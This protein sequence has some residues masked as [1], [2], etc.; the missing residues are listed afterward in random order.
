VEGRGVL[1]SRITFSCKAKIRDAP[2]PSGKLAAACFSPVQLSEEKF[3][4]RSKENVMKTDPEK[5]EFSRVPIHLD[6]EIS[7]PQPA[8]HPCQVKDVSLKGLYLLCDNPLPV[9]SVCR[10]A[11]L[12]NGGETPVRIE[13]GGTVARVDTT[14]MGLEITEIV[15]IESFEHLQNLVLYNASDPDQ[16]AHEFQSHLGLK[17]KEE[18][19]S[20]KK[21]VE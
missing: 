12:L 7:S 11:L 17:R 9:G 1:L 19:M 18:R 20:T 4:R 15:G 3:G 13:L 21:P 14:G 10:V 2:G 6:V 5:R 8:P 16:V